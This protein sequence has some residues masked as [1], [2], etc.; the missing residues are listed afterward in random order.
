[1]RGSGYGSIQS[2]AIWGDGYGEMV[3]TGRSVKL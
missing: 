1:M 2:V 3:R